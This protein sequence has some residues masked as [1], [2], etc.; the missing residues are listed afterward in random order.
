MEE[1]LLEIKDI[2]EFSIGYQ[3]CKIRGV[4]LEDVLRIKK[5]TQHNSKNEDELQSYFMSRI[6]KFLNTKGKK[7]IGW[8][9]ILEGGLPK[10]AKMIS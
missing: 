5:N 9:E 7:L 1:V 8:D 4:A 2:G 3:K 6:E 10:K